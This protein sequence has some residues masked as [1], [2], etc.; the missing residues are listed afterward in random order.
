MDCPSTH[1]YQGEFKQKVHLTFF[2]KTILQLTVWWLLSGDFFPLKSEFGV[3]TQILFQVLIVKGLQ[4]GF[5]EKVLEFPPCPTGSMPGS[6]RS[7]YWLRLRWSEMVTRGAWRNIPS[8]GRHLHAHSKKGY[9]R[10]DWFK[11]GLWDWTFIMLDCQSPGQLC[12]LGIF[13][14]GYF[15][16]S[17]TYITSIAGCLSLGLM[18]QTGFGIIQ[19]QT[20]LTQ[21]LSSH[22]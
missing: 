12:H 6:S 8:Q 21:P 1:L 2:M 4:G 13:I 20:S 19:H 11:M 3:K 18:S 16:I 22:H 7:C 10:R 17:A 14:S 5:C 9:F 15:T